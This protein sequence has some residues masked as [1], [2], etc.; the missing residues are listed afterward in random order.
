MTS[1]NEPLTRAVV[2][3]GA[4]F[5]RGEGGFG[6]APKFPSETSLLFLLGRYERTGAPDTLEMVTVSLDHMAAGGIYD[7][8]GGGFHRYSVDARWQVPHFEKMLYNQAWLGRAY[9]EAARL[10]G[11]PDYERVVRETLRYV[12]RDLTSPEGAFYTAEDADSEGEEGLFYIWTPQQVVDLLGEK[13]A[14]LF[15]AYYGVTPSGNFEHGTSILHVDQPLEAF[16]RQRGLEPDAL[17]S[18]LE[19]AGGKLLEVRA[20]RPRPLRDDKLITGW[21]GMMIGTFA[22]AGAVL[23]DESFVEVARRAANYILS[24]MVDDDGNLLRVRRNGVSKI[25]AFQED[26]AYLVDALIEL[27]EATGDDE[28]HSA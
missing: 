6:G 14:E 2:Q 17:W 8:L 1:P 3:L 18:R 26:Y 28:W 12:L 13:D 5:D 19:A 16:A 22:A 9:L 4:R 24:V 15:N 27:Y 21:N 23:E 7:H 25:P 20:K 11:D 10:T